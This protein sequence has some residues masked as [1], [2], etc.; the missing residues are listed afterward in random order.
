MGDQCPV[1]AFDHTLAL[2]DGSPLSQPTA[3][4][5]TYDDAAASNA[6]SVSMA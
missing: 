4:V 2:F 5:G 1:N 6:S 3:Q